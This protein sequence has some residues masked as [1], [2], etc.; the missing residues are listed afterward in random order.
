MKGLGLLITLGYLLLTSSCSTEYS[1]Y[2]YDKENLHWFICSQDHYIVA[3]DLGDTLQIWNLTHQCN[4]GYGAAEDI[5]IPKKVGALGETKNFKFQME[6]TKLTDRRIEIKLNRGGQIIDFNLSRQTRKGD[7]FRVINI[8]QMLKVDIE[9]EKFVH[10]NSPHAKENHEYVFKGYV[11]DE[12][13]ETMDPEKFHKYYRTKQ[14]LKTQTILK[15]LAE[16]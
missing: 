2:Y 15:E 13:V 7:A 1:E 4:S 16:D 8:I 9:M 5:K 14:W 10:A 11:V 12:N 3:K 6:I